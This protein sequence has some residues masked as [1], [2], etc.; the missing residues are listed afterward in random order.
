MQDFHMHLIHIKIQTSLGP[1]IV[2]SSFNGLVN[3][4][5]VGDAGGGGGVNK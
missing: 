5:W 2:F 1:A 4:G 3:V